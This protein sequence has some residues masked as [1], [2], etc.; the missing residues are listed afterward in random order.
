MTAA[1]GNVLHVVDTLA[2]GGTQTILKGYFESR[3]ADRSIHLYGM[4]AVPGQLEVAHP[5][6]GMSGSSLRFSMAP[7]LGL[8]RIVRGQAIGVLHCHLFRAQV[9]G[10]LLKQLFFPGITLVFHEHGRAVGRE[11]ESGL[12]ASMY[13]WFLWMA[14]RRV[15]HF[16]CISDHTRGRL[17]Q[18][19]PQAAGKLTVVA[20]PVTVHPRQQGAQDRSAIRREHGIPDGAFVVG[21]ASRLV[22]RKG[23]GDFLDAVALVIAAEPVYFLVAG[24]GEDRE[25]AQDRIRELHLEG[26]GR[27]LGH[28]D[29]MTQFY[30]CLDCFVM[31]SHWEPH[32]LAHLEAQG[33]GVPV[34]VSDAPGLASTVRDG[35]DALLF[36]PGDAPGLAQCMRRLKADDALRV[37]LIAG[38]LANSGRFTIDAFA[39]SLE[40]VYASIASRRLG[41]VG[42]GARKDAG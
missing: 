6:V 3:A 15:D 37:R 38:G 14:W 10:L 7:L 33:F 27:M 22:Q 35:Y 21:F 1:L 2:A 28:I 29:G 17:L 32:G 8:R 19:I 30:A 42:K 11:G 26:R 24:D 9:F 20:N 39:A 16:I 31:P 18:V 25:K 36:K 41:T 5:N 13:R 34:V 4:R 12:E 40:D 23:W